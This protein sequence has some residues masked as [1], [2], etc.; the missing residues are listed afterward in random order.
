MLENHFQVNEIW[1]ENGCQT[2]QCIPSNSTADPNPQP[3]LLNSSCSSMFFSDAFR[4]RSSKSI[5]LFFWKDCSFFSW[6]TWS[7]CSAACGQGVQTRNRSCLYLNTNAPCS[8]CSGNYSQSQICQQP[9]CPGRCILRCENSNS[10][11][12]SLVCEF[13]PYLPA[14]AC[15]KTCG[16]GTWLLNQTCWNIADTSSS[17]PT[18]CS[19][20]SA[21]GTYT[22]RSETCNP[23]VCI[24]KRWEGW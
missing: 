4:I 1:Q 23:D 22:V 7:T 20:T 14:T 6:S 24:S 5:D 19:N 16:N 13:S 10:I 15:T 2:Y 12:S 11:V 18:T 17:I 9:S 3:V 21:C 8:S